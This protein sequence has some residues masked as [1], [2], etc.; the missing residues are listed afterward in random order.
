L[1]P[2]LPAARDRNGGS[3]QEIWFQSSLN[4]ITAVGQ[5]GPC[6]EFLIILKEL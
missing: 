1:L 2:A 5:S 6:T 3:D 4:S